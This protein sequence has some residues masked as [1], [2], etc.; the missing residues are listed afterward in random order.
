VVE[1]F[2]G[3]RAAGFAA[4]V[5]RLLRPR[6]VAMLHAHGEAEESRSTRAAVTRGSM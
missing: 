5:Q 6:P 4:L 2:A 3:E 1:G